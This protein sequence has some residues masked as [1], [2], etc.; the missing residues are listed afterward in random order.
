MEKGQ[1]EGVGETQVIQFLH[2]WPEHNQ[3]TVENLYLF[4]SRLHQVHLQSSD[5]D[6]IVVVS[7]VC[8]VLSLYMFILPALLSWSLPTRKRSTQSE[9]LS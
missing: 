3:Y 6:F 9:H 1:A 7:G 5:Y 8:P 2:S 4:G